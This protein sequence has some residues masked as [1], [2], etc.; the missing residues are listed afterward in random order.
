V[1]TRA[2]HGGQLP[3]DFRLREAS[4]F[5]TFV[6]GPNTELAAALR[7]AAAGTG[8]AFYLHGAAGSGRTHLLEAT[9]RA[10]AGA[11]RTSMYLPLAGHGGFGPALLDG[12]DQV[13]VLCLDDL[14][15]LAGERPWEQRLVI[16]L[17]A[18]REAGSLLVVAA[19]AA[20]AAL[21]ALLPDLASRLSR[22]AIYPLRALEDADRLRVLVVRAR[23]RGLELSEP[24]AR[25]LLAHC[26]RDF[27]TLFA[28][29]DRIDRASLADQRRVTLPF[30]R[31]LLGAPPA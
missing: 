15:A 8:G 19:A 29:L 31:A 14:Q 24:V 28:V 2:G 25:Y 23:L 27:D 26:A 18:L 6:P 1:S 20:P 21:P 7:S 10:A 11:G 5:D 3:F 13:A 17:D 9:C 22:A 12:L 30:V 4:T 16:L